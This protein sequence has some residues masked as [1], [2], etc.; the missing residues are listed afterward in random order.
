MKNDKSVLHTRSTTMCYFMIVCILYTSYVLLSMLLRIK[1]DFGRGVGTITVKIN[2][3]QF[4]AFF[5]VHKNI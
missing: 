4:R 2:V 3:I 1:Y 5:S